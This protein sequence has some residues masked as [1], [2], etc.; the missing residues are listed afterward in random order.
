MKYTVYA[1]DKI[2]YKQVIEAESAEEAEELAMDLI[3]EW[4]EIPT[5]GMLEILIGETD[6]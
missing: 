2:L 6:E 1:E 3:D 5:E 4:E